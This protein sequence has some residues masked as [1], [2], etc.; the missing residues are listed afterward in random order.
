MSLHKPLI[1]VTEGNKINLGKFVPLTQDMDSTQLKGHKLAYNTLNVAIPMI[2][3]QNYSNPA[4][5]LVCSLSFLT[6]I[7]N[8]CPN[9]CTLRKGKYFHS[10]KELISATKMIKVSHT[11]LN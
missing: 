5:Y 1:F 10:K 3:L 6:V 7:I 11:Q 2:M 4:A 8:S 9:D